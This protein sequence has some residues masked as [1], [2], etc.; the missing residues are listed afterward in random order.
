MLACR[1]EVIAW[2]IIMAALVAVTIAQRVVRGACSICI[3]R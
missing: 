1:D 2:S 3:D